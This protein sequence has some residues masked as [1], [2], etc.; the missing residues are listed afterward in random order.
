MIRATLLIFTLFTLPALSMVMSPAPALAQGG[1][2]CAVAYERGI[3]EHRRQNAAV[4][5][6]RD[7]WR[8][9]VRNKY[10]GVRLF[11][12]RRAVDAPGSGGC[13]AGSAYRCHIV[14]QPCRNA[15]SV[16]TN[17]N[18]FGPCSVLL[19]YDQARANGCTWY[20]RR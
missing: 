2:A 6:A 13:E 18:A 1:V 11:S 19:P 4:R 10:R 12:L 3:G 20:K 7:A 9:V 5:A 8:D 14:A 16:A 15:G 17:S